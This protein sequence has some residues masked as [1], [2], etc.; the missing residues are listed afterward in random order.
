M[1]AFTDGRSPTR[2]EASRCKETRERMRPDCAAIPVL[3]RRAVYPA[4][5]CAEYL[6]SRSGCRVANP[7]TTWPGR[8][9][10]PLEPIR[11]S[12]S[13][14]PHNPTGPSGRLSIASPEQLTDPTR[15]TAGMRRGCRTSRAGRRGRCA[16]LFTRGPCAPAA[17]T[18]TTIARSA[19]GL[20]AL[21]MSM[22]VRF[23]GLEVGPGGLE[24][25]VEAARD[26]EL[27]RSEG[28]SRCGDQSN[29][30]P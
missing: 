6:L 7:T 17:P 26:A 11:N 29:G 9:P 21:L 20:A 15:G 24:H 1:F 10:F 4:A 12:L 18:C 8:A 22:F 5:A 27:W 2:C 23:V 19:T 3:R 13:K 14:R 16:P 28:T 25:H 30:G